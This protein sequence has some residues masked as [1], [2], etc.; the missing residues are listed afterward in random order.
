M[1]HDPLHLGTTG[2]L[3]GPVPALSS[4]HQDQDKAL[5]GLVQCLL[6]VFW[7]RPLVMNA[8]VHAQA[9]HGVLMPILLIA[10]NTQVKV[11]QRNKNVMED[12]IK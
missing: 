9:C 10:T 6:R 7:S 11:L 3:A 2:A 4:V 12:C 8:Q 5:N 1:V